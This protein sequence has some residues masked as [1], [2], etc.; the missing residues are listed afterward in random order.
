MRDQLFAAP[1]PPAVRDVRYSFPQALID[2]GD[3]SC[4]SVDLGGKPTRLQKLVMLA[5]WDVIRGFYRI[6]RSRLPP[7]DVDDA[8]AHA[9]IHRWGNGRQV[10]YRPG[11]VTLA[12]AGPG[13]HFVREYLP[14]SVAYIPVD[15]AERVVLAQIYCG[16]EPVLHADTSGIPVSCFGASVLDNGILAPTTRQA[17]SLRLRNLAD[18][19]IRVR[20]LAF[21]AEL[22]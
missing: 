4:V 5:E 15:P 18:V 11:K 6:K 9:R 10:G 19:Q 14:S 21:G 8:V 1:R 22:V 16:R 7:I 13:R 17:L 2:P 3:E 12:Y 20:A